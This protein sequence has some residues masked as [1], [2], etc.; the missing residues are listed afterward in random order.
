MR[1]LSWWGTHRM[2]TLAK[3]S[4]VRLQIS[5]FKSHFGKVQ[6]LRLS[7][8]RIH[9]PTEFPSLRELGKTATRNGYDGGLRLILASWK[10]FNEYCDTHNIKLED[11][12]FTISCETN[13]PRQVGLGSSSAIITAAIEALMQFYGV[14][15]TSFPKPIQPDLIS[16]VE[17]EEL[18]ISAGLQDRVIQVYSSTVSD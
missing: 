8:H 7:P 16:S 12:N 1:G 17:T 5:A 9:D 10:K 4:P 2:G 14:T 18:G 3:W 11:K 6:P 13:I 15:K